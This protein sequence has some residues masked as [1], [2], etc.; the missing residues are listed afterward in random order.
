MSNIPLCGILVW[1]GVSDGPSDRAADHSAM[2]RQH[3]GRWSVALS[4]PPCTGTFVDDCHIQPDGTLQ[5]ESALHGSCGIDNT[6]PSTL[7]LV[8]NSQP[9]VKA[10]K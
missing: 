5:H 9:K 4:E 8:M 3:G 6:L 10:C 1:G 7:T 2:D